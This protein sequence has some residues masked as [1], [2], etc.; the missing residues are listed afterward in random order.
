MSSVDVLIV[1]F[2]FSK[3]D[4]VSKNNTDG[5]QQNSAVEQ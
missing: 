5:K 2:R 1:L 4:K 3:Q